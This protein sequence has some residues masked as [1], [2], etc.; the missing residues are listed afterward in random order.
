[1]ASEYEIILRTFLPPPHCYSVF[2][3]NSDR[4][5]QLSCSAEVDI[6]DTFSMGTAK[7]GQSL[8]GHSIPHMDGWSKACEKSREP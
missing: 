8:F 4:Q 5:Q 1:M 3:L 7:D 2:R 6:T